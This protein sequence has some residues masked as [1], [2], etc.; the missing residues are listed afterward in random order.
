MNNKIYS[1]NNDFII[2][3][4]ETDIIELDSCDT[5]KSASYNVEYTEYLNW[6]EQINNLSLN[7]LEQLIAHYY[8]KLNE[9]C[10]CHSFS[11]PIGE[12]EKQGR[13]N[14]FWS[15]INLL[16]YLESVWN[17]KFNEL[18]NATKIA[19]LVAIIK[20]GRSR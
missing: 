10:M 2:K 19:K 18:D 9:V 11:A 13:F 1:I 7:E 8:D 12:K 5:C 4:G 14:E 16:E 17:R 20:Q 6:R 15:L 3:T